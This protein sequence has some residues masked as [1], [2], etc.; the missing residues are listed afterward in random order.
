MN[1]KTDLAK[2]V[3]YSVSGGVLTAA[4]GLL[5]ATQAHAE[6]RDTAGTPSAPA[7][8]P[9]PTNVSSANAAERKQETAEKKTAELRKKV[10]ERDGSSSANAA[11]R[12]RENSEKRKAEEE[13]KPKPAAKKDKDTSGEDR[14][15]NEG[16]KGEKKDEEVRP[17]RA[18]KDD[19]DTPQV[20]K[21]SH[22]RS[23]ESGSA[24]GR[25]DRDAVPPAPPPR[26]VVDKD[27]KREVGTVQEVLASG[28]QSRAPGGSRELLDELT[29]AGGRDNEKKPVPEKPGPTPKHLRDA[30]NGTHEPSRGADSLLNLPQAGDK[31][32]SKSGQR[33]PIQEALRALRNPSRNS[34][35]PLDRFGRPRGGNANPDPD[36]SPTQQAD[37]PDKP[38]QPPD[39]LRDL[40]YGERKP[41]RT[42]PL[43]PTARNVEKTGRGNSRASAGPAHLDGILT[44][45]PA[46][47][48]ED[49]FPITLPRSDKPA[50]KAKSAGTTT[51]TGTRTEQVTAGDPNDHWIGNVSNEAWEAIQEI[52]AGIVEFVQGVGDATALSKPWAVGRDRYREAKE[53]QNQ[54]SEALAEAV[55]NPRKAVE[56]TVR[57]YTEEWNGDQPER[58]I[59]RALVEIPSAF[60]GGGM[61]AAGRAGKAADALPE[62]SAPNPEPSTGTPPRTDSEPGSGGPETGNPPSGDLADT[63]DRAP[64][65]PERQNEAERA[66]SAPSGVKDSANDRNSRGDASEPRTSSGKSDDRDGRDARVR[67]TPATQLPTLP[68]TDSPDRRSADTSR[69]DSDTPPA[70]TSDGGESGQRSPEASRTTSPA[71]RDTTEAPRCATPNSFVPGT[72]VLLAD[73]TYKPIEQVR[74]GDR[75]LATDPVTGLTQA[76]PVIALIPGQGLKE[77]VRITVD[78]DGD[79]GNATGVVTATDEHPFWT[80]DDGRWTEAED[81]DQGSLLRTP[82]GR[83]LE[84]VAVHEWAQPQQVHNFT[85]EGLHTYYVNAGGQ[86]L[87]T[88]NAGG[89]C[90]VTGKPHGR[91]GEDSTE[92]RL[93]NAG[94]TDIASE[95][96]FRTTGGVRFRADFVARDPQGNVVVVES[97]TGKRAK[98]TAN[99]RIGYPSLHQNGAYVRSPKLRHL[100]LPQGTFVRLPVEFDMWECPEC[101]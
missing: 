64:T 19:E 25:D 95:V 20:R 41:E 37:R 38:F 72:P 82:D 13:R 28:A 68:R 71:A 99:Q 16:G 57:P 80:A 26:V 85:V 74:L 49:Q 6:P 18:S 24:G 96:M 88:H 9:T 78:T 94:Y 62:R 52:P 48:R 65:G 98:L 61:G 8:K 4:F 29:S 59:G 90:P 92:Q 40:L 67:P 44:D 11:D 51:S 93:R 36:S 12:R 91:M 47:R 101:S 17:E 84:V 42:D 34:A 33:E 32:E 22:S 83:L 46:P 7:K 14:G 66:D 58:V 81:L 10:Q 2:A 23:L 15:R 97:K 30:V 79:Q 63:P 86:S 43:L 70:R 35:D 31:Q 60:L 45:K 55:E 39:H 73:G 1:R 75:V 53:R 21:A 77:L 100:G 27:T 50:P 87:L 3:L 89:E 54:R 69:R 76:R 56:D 5:G